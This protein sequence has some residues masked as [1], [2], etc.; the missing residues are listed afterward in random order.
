MT[1]TPERVGK[2]GT[3]TACEINQMLDLID[4]NFKVAIINMFKELKEIMIK[5]IKEGM[6]TMLHQIEN[7]NKEVENI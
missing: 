6:M 3:K 4:I 2:Q 5:E 1:H 7:I